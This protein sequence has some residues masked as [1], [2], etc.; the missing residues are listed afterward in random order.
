VA[1][2]PS[3]IPHRMVRNESL[4]CV[5]ENLTATVQFLSQVPCTSTLDTMRRLRKRNP[6]R[7]WVDVTR[8]SNLDTAAVDATICYDDVP[9]PCGEQTDESSISQMVL[10]GVPA[11]QAKRAL[12]DEVKR[13]CVAPPV[14][15]VTHRRRCVT[16]VVTL[17]VAVMRI[18]RHPDKFQ[19]KLGSRLVE[20]DRERIM[21]RVNEVSNAITN[22]WSALP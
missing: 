12:R 18:D 1:G 14:R 6:E 7:R 11:H 21:A 19:Q 16:A 8:R 5:A 17:A 10:L 20:A 4:E 13:W 15:P 2:A 9:W 3:E 22:A